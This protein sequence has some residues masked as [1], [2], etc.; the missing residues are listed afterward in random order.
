MT[1]NT[2]RGD[3]FRSSD[4]MATIDDLEQRFPVNR[5]T[6]AG[7]PLWPLVRVRWFFDEWNRHHS[8]GGAGGGLTRSRLSRLAGLGQRHIDGV[9]TD[10]KDPGGRQ[11]PGSVD[12]AMLSD[13]VLRR[14]GGQWVHPLC[15]PIVDRLKARGLRVGVMSP[16]V[17]GQLP[18]A[19]PSVVVQR[20]IDAANALGALEARLRPPAAA[21][22]DVD[23]VR[24]FVRAA[25]SGFDG[26]VFSRSHLI[27]LGARVARLADAWARR[28]RTWRP[29]L[30]F[31]VSYYGVEGMAFALACHR[32]GIPVVELQ[33]G[34]QGGLHPAYAHLV[35]DAGARHPLLP[36]WFWVWSAWEQDVITSWAS[37]TRHRVVVGGNPWLAAWQETPTPVMREA[38]ARASSL[39]ARAGGRPIILVTLQPGLRADEQL[40]PVRRLAD[41]L[42]DGHVVWIRLH[43][44]MIAER[45]S[46]R[47][48]FGGVAVELDEPSDLPLPA[49]LPAAD[50]HVTHSS[51]TVI[52]AVGFGVRSVLYSGY[53]A[54][55]FEPLVAR[56]LAVASSDDEELATAVVNAAARG[57]VPV[58]GEHLI[59][60][61][62][63]EI[64]ASLPAAQ[65]GSA[66]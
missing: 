26:A 30:A 56:G 53:G 64:L 47:R 44:V 55:L 63:D 23:A 24:S 32:A 15:D 16:A 11:P 54:E 34:V 57:R 10:R 4:V 51:S 62:L 5:W 22:D 9:V 12:V 38:M 59:E 39:Q 37:P 46:I 36:D 21:L 28:L 58:Q 1:T 31:Q 29:R 6:V 65:K 45:E 60:G 50:V 41:R 17:G 52:D 13:G 66:A 43:P 25:G 8:P 3:G 18:R 35:V 19:C 40:E 49:V 7:I 61:A 42:G 48:A 20:D 14:L 2:T 27:S 33:H